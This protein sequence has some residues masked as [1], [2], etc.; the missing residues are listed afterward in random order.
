MSQ[1]CWYQNYAPCGPGIQQQW[2]RW[3]RFY[4]KTYQVQSRQSFSRQ[5]FERQKFEKEARILYDDQIRVALFSVGGP[6]MTFL[7]TIAS[8][9]VLWYGGMQVIQGHLTA[10]QLT[11]STFIWGY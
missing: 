8:S 7:T 2:L 6:L 5:Q 9:L 10:G 1:L 11:T 4:R 3:V